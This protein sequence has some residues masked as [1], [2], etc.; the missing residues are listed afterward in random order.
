MPPHRDRL[1]QIVRELVPGFRQQAN[2]ERSALVAA[3][4]L[5]IT[6]AQLF[7]VTGERGKHASSTSSAR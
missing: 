7:G 2:V 5:K 3:G 4:A 1:Y 6:I